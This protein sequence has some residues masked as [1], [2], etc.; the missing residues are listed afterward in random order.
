[1]SNTI[2]L[3]RSGTANTQ[4]VAANLSLGELAINYADGD[5]FYKDGSNVVHIIASSS[6][7]NVTGNIRGANLTINAGGTV[8]FAST[9]NVSLGNVSNVHIDGGAADYVL[10]TDGS[11]NLTWSA[12]GSPTIIQNGL[13]NVT[14]PVANGNVYINSNNGTDQE[15]IFTTG[16]DLLAPGNINAANVN[17]GNLSLTG[18]ILSD[19][20]VDGSIK[21]SGSISALGNVVLNG[22]I[23]ALGDITGNNVSATGNITSTNGYI[24]ANGNITTS[25]GSISAFGNITGANVNTGNLS[26]TGNILS[27]ANVDGSIK[28]SGS[29]SA[30]GNVVLNGF[31]SALGDIT[32][33]NVS[34]TGNITSTNGYISANGNITT[35]SGSISAFGN[36]TGANVNT[37]NLSLTGNILSDA[38]VDGNIKTSGSISALGN[39]VLNGFISALGDITGNNVSAS[40]NITSSSG[41]ISASGNV[42]GG[43]IFTNGLISAN[44][45]VT[46]SN[47]IVNA[48][49]YTASITGNTTLS[50]TTVSG[51][52]INIQPQGSGN[53]VL[54]NTYINGVANPVQDQDVASK[55]YVDQ[56]AT[57]G[58]TFHAPVYVTTNTDLDTATG[59]TV[60][61]NQ[62]NGAGN[63]IGATLTTTGSFYLIDTANVQTVGTRILVKN[64]SNGA[65]N[66]VYTYSNTTAIVRSTDTDQYGSDSTE[67]FSINDY[68][69]TQNGNV[70]AGSAFVVSAPPGT[71]TFGTSNIQFSQFSSTQVYTAN[72]NAGLSLTGT[73]FSAKVDNNTTAFD[74]GGNIIVKASANLT[75]PNIGAATGTSIS[76]TGDITAANLYSNGLISATGN[77]VSG[78]VNT[79]GLV[80]A[81]GNVTSGN[82]LTG[83]LISATG[84][85][86]GG[87]VLTGGLI[88]AT[89]NITGGNVLFGSGIV[90]G[91]G[92]VYGGNILQGSFQVLDTASTI[93]GGQYT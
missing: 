48:V 53:I 91:T 5:L 52:N 37:G 17:T 15:W 29:I 41:Y 78:N 56:I 46:G 69:F 14:I 28:T 62:P 81:V 80:S 10:T 89:G 19:V 70:N 71:I 36:I 35:S 38:N 12:T 73:V 3:K 20:N 33:N 39:V 82:V 87:N 59:G 26:L 31:I 72:T 9:S 85:I 74:A 77:L 90:S 4:P 8:N 11:G 83:G 6:N 47:V 34:A 16:G 32:G 27:D 88:S 65:F 25:S 22:F 58:L 43:N 49:L 79:S 61:Y 21:T 51:G 24:S 84:N 44:G 76:L 45:N 92:N 86:T 66:G 60:S 30:L 54:A 23:S 63:G 7:M 1:M 75:T 2:L 55:Y 50:L 18:N 67:S 64:E 40:G 68:F 57:T 13:S 93:D 42:F